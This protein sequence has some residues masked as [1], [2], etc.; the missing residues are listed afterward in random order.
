[1]KKHLCSCALACFLLMNLP[2]V[3]QSENYHGAVQTQVNDSGALLLALDEFRGPG[4][5]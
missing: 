2:G 4:H 3:A 1:M 5:L